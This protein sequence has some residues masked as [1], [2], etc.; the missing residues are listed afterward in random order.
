VLFYLTG[1]A[2]ASAARAGSFVI[3]G[4][5]MLCRVKLLHD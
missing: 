5:V 4:P 2:F 1:S 3:F